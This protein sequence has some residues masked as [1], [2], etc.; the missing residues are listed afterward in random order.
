MCDGENWSV[1][2]INAIEKSKFWKST[3]IV[4]TW[5]DFGGFYDHVPPPVINNIAFGPRVPTIVISPFARLHTVDHNVY[6][7]GS[8]LKFA[9]DARPDKLG[10]R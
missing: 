6:D 5:D 2:Q 4:L 3:A 7:F 1:E 8:M 10:K 9:E